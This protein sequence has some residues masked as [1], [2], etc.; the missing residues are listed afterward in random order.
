M[1]GQKTDTIIEI[2]GPLTDIQRLAIFAEVAT[3]FCFDCGRA[4]EN[5]TE[6]YC[7]NEE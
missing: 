6:C 4:L 7:C 5:E 3:H 1:I 2:L